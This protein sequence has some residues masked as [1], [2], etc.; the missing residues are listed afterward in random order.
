MGGGIL[1]VARYKDKIYFLYGREAIRGHD[2]DAG[3]WS[4]FGGAKEKHE[5]PKQTA[6]REGYEETSGILGSQTNIKNLIH[7]DL[8]GT[9]YYRGYTI[10]L[11][12][13]PYSRHLPKRLSRRYNYALKKEPEKVF[14]HNGL[15]EKDKA[16]WM[17]LQN[18]KDR[19]NIFRPWY[20][21]MV[22]KTIKFFERKNKN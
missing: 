1:P 6:I 3:L 7:Y 11:V 22:L 9:I 15:Y 8:L 5:T 20:R 2:R 4:D 18:L 19:I 14:A 12:E 16:E 10:F 17:E 13:I 21:T